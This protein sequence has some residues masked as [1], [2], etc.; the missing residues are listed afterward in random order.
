MRKY[1][2]IILASIALLCSGCSYQTPQE[3]YAEYYQ[4]YKDKDRMVMVQVMFETRY[5]DVE[6]SVFDTQTNQFIIDTKETNFNRTFLAHYKGRY[7]F[8]FTHNGK[9]LNDEPYT[10]IHIR[11]ATDNHLI[12]EY[13][14]EGC[15]VGYNNNFLAL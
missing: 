15:L 10:F 14:L 4:N 1:I 13:E 7:I 5:T 12:D 3:E 9:A 8:N 2:Y 6:V 11:N